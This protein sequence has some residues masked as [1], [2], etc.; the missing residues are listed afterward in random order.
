MDLLASCSTNRS[1]FDR[2]EAHR[3]RR[4]EASSARMQELEGSVRRMHGDLTATSQ[5]LTATSEEACHVTSERDNLRRAYR[6]LMEQFELLRR[7]IFIA[8]AE[9]IDESARARVRE[10][11]QKLDELAQKLGGEAAADTDTEPRAD[12]EP[13]GSRPSGKPPGK[14]P[15]PKGRRTWP[16]PTICPAPHRSSKHRAREEW[17]RLHRLGAELQARL[18]ATGAGSGGHCACQ[19]QGACRGC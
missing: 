8:K 11:Q 3:E 6:Q 10:D 17:R 5:K 4:S 9:R 13:I 7:R 14:P 1:R 19:V 16:T 12:Q 2:A 15:S 18:S